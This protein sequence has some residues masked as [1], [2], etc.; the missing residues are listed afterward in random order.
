MVAA[1]AVGAASGLMTFLVVRLAWY[2][3]LSNLIPEGY[4]ARGSQG[5]CSGPGLGEGAAD[6]L[7]WM[8]TGPWISALFGVLAGLAHDAALVSWPLSVFLVPCVIAGLFHGRHLPGW[9]RRRKKQSARRR[10]KGPR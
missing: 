3:P 2:G 7:G 9:L 8:L 10:S 1:V 5:G 4:Y 6:M